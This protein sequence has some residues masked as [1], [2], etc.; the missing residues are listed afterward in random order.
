MTESAWVFPGQGSQF[1]GMG[2]DL[3]ENYGEAR[4]VFE[5]ADSA[6]GQKLSELCFQ[7]PEAE[8]TDTINAQPALLT[9]S[10]AALA[11]LKSSLGASLLP[12]LFTAGHSLGEYSALVAADSLDFADAVRLVRARGAAMKRAGEVRPG[13]MAALLGLDDE[14]VAA[15]CREVGG[16]QVANYNAPGQI[17]VSGEKGALDRVLALAKQAGAKRAMPLAV[18]IAAHSELMRPAADEFRAAVDAT[19]IRPP[20]LTVISN[21][22]ALPLESIEAIRQEM[23]AQLTSPVQWVKSVQYM[24]LGGVQRFYEIGS[25]DVLAGLI[26]RIVKDGQAFSIGN[27]A[28][29]Q[30]FAEPN[31]SGG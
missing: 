10:T 12:P 17:V 25:K 15:I 28:N 21:I 3:F 20:R 24:A 30:S 7:G 26:R 14:R 9:H 1:V 29:V 19:D 2:R 22:T 16:V 8:L 18:S 11:V 6:L 23:V 13:A 31:P 27:V 5:A 4:A